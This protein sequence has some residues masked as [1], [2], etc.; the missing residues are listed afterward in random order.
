MGLSSPP[1]N[2]SGGPPTARDVVLDDSCSLTSH[3]NIDTSAVTRPSLAAV[4]HPVAD[5]G[6]TYAETAERNRETVFEVVSNQK[7]FKKKRK[8][9]LGKSTANTVFK[10]VVKKQRKISCQNFHPRLKYQQKSQGDTFLCSPGIEALSACVGNSSECL[11]SRNTLFKLLW[12][13]ANP[14]L[15]F[16]LLWGDCGRRGWYDCPQSALRPAY[17]VAQC[18]C[19]PRCMQISIGLCSRCSAS[20]PEAGVYSVR[21][22]L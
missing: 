2:S 22:V 16:P 10:G 5:R 21:G 6:A 3:D 9:V 13:R 11:S 7:A 15:S 14:F 20:L 18:A 4:T 12:D 8:L 17:N 19:Y 1:I